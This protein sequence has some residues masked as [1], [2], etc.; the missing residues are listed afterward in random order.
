MKKVHQNQINEICKKLSSLVVDGQ[1]ALRDIYSIG[2]KTLIG[3]VPDT[4]GQL[5]CERLTTKLISGISSPTTTEDIKREC[6]DILSE[7]LKRFGGYNESEHNQ[8]MLILIEQLKN[9]KLAI[10]KRAS[11]ALGNL[12]VVS[13]DVLLNAVI[14]VL[15]T[16]IQ[17][18]QNSPKALLTSS[19]SQEIR[20][21][22]QT[23][24]TISRNVGYRL[25][26]YVNTII[27]LFLEFCG[28]ARSTEEEEN[29]QVVE[30]ANELR[31]YCFPGIE[32]FLLR[33]SKE[34][35]I[36]FLP[37]ILAKAIEFMKYDPNYMYDDEDADGNAMETEEGT[38]GG[39]GGGD[40]DDYGY[41]DGGYEEEEYHA[42][43]DDDSSW[44]VR[45]VAT[46]V[47]IAMITFYSEQLLTIQPM[48]GMILLQRFK[49]REE[50]VR[51]DIIFAF[52]KL[53]EITTS[54][55]ASSTAGDST[56]HSQQPQ[57]PQQQ[58]QSQARSIATIA[59]NL[60]LEET[61]VAATSGYAV[62][63]K[64]SSSPDM[65]VLLTSIVMKLDYVMNTIFANQLQSTSSSALKTKEAILL[66]LKSFIVA[67]QVRKIFSF[68]FCQRN[69]LK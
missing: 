7:L 68:S 11:T 20:T 51:L 3:D 18:L 66:L 41:E 55:R 5:V 21:L 4:M 50:N 26:R 40:E 49:E 46:K 59:E 29:D 60:W 69:F 65:N 45:K 2:L 22:I 23:I 34:T 54:T 67:F 28:S 48:M 61:T 53:L 19:S 27:P 25:S 12:V 42:S 58:S 6:L 1:A 17:E 16:R 14:Q 63:Q 32:S 30:L 35:M 13:S 39:G 47:I 36:P 52:M 62:L 9:D 43:D 15:L 44:K 38:G 64:V 31:E 33:C 24:G 56:G 37:S 57:Q 8:I 10:R